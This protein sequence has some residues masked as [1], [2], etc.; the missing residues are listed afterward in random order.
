[1]ASCIGE[2]F[3][4]MNIPGCSQVFIVNVPEYSFGRIPVY[5]LSYYSCHFSGEIAWYENFYSGGRVDEFHD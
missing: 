5:D 1:M 3:N 4:L 2:D